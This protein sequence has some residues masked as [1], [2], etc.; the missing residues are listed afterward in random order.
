MARSEMGCSR[1]RRRQKVFHSSGGD[2]SGAKLGKVWGVGQ[3]H[4]RPVAMIA[5]CANPVCSAPFHYLREGKV[6]RME[7]DSCGSPLG[8]KLAGSKP[9]RKIEHFWLCG[10]C[11]TTLTLV[12]KQGKVEAVPIEP[13]V[14][15]RALAS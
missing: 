7:F 11:S 10:P 5:K 2:H 15:T 3:L 8:P 1:Q 6:F 14:I 12:M 9:V 13:A 4:G